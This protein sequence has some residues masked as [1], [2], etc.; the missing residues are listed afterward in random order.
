MYKVKINTRGYIAPLGMDGPVVTAL[1]LSDEMTLNL[2]KRGYSISEV[3]VSLNK[4]LLLTMENFNNASRWDAV[5]V[6]EASIGTAASAVATPFAQVSTSTPA[7][8]PTMAPA[9]NT[10]KTHK[11]IKAE[12][13]AAEEE[14]KKKA[15]IVSG[16]VEVTTAEATT[17]VVETTEEV[18]EATV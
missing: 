4:T 16:T 12:R 2:I 6:S 8:A 15:A 18:T 13:R 3:S 5:T 11:E 9:T 14:A 10:N 1:E 17:E 7:V